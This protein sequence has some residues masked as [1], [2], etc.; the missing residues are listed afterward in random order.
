[1]GLLSC[2]ESNPSRT[3]KGL[4]LNRAVMYTCVLYLGV[5]VDLLAKV[6]VTRLGEGKLSSKT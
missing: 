1:M 6:A 5:D 4:L 3:R 2:G